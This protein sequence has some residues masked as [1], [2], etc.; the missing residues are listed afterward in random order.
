MTDN[1]NFNF[2]PEAPQPAE[3]A[4]AYEAA[5]QAIQNA[6]GTANAAAETVENAAQSFQ[7]TAE[8]FQMPEAPAAPEPPVY[9]QP[10][11]EQAQQYAPPQYTAPQYT[12]PQQPQQQAPQYQPPIYGQA[13]VQ[14]PVQPQQ[15]YKTF[16]DVP[17][18][19]Y[20]QKSRLAAGLLGIMLGGF[21]IHNFYLEN[22]NRAI[23][24]LVISLV[25]GV[26]TCGVATIAM[27]VWGIVEGIQ[28]F[29]GT[30]PERNYDGNGVI[31]RD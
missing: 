11:Q 28:I 30:N 2:T 26:I 4:Q 3:A 27:E 8:S 16:Y 1:N 15:Q 17:P 14:Q 10:V 24:Q 13:P 21:G 5:E 9:Q 31:L 22:K 12:V 6:A 29:Q 18:V 20:Q 7:S 23:I 19:G 25:G